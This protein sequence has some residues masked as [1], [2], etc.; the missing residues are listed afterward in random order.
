[1]F[2][3]PPPM[4]A[5]DAFHRRQFSLRPLFSAFISIIFDTTPPPFSPMRR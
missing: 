3:A 4:P 1:M 5:F 2:F